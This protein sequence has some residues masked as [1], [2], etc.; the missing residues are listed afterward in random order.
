[1]NT[2]PKIHNAVPAEQVTTLQPQKL[3]RHYHRIPGYVRDTAFRYPRLVSDYFLGHYRLS[4]ELQDVQVDE[5]IENPPEC[6]YQSPIG[7][8]GFGIDRSLLGEVLESYYGGALPANQELPPESSS[9]ARM[10]E[11]LGD[12]VLSRLGQALLAGDVPGPLER[13]HDSYAEVHWEYAITLRYISHLSERTGDLRIYLDAAWTDELIRRVSAPAA[14]RQLG[15]PA[16][17]IQRLP[18]R[19]DC[20]LARARLSLAD[21]LGLKVGDLLLIRMEER[22]EV[23]I[24]RQK[25]FHGALFD[26]QGTLF[27]TFLE[28]EKNA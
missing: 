20:V 9:E 1:M 27:L 8:L 17:A 7:N 26:D 22:V 19:L 11:R 23:C 4:I 15:N 25:L 21:V 12:H 28:S 10:R 16:R 6:I 24:N 13:Q 2:S 3:G 18:V 5:A 14:P